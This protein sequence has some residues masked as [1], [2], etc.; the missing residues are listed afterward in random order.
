MT[1]DLKCENLYIECPPKTRSPGWH[2]W[3][4]V[5][6]CAGSVQWKISQSL[7]HFLFLYFTSCPQHELF[8]SATCSHHDVLPLHM[9]QP[10]SP[11]LLKPWASSL[12]GLIV[13]DIYHSN[14]TL[15]NRVIMKRTYFSS[16]VLMHP[17]LLQPSTMIQEDSDHSKCSHGWCSPNSCSC[18][19]S[20]SS[21]KILHP[22][23]AFENGP[24][25][26]PETFTTTILQNQTGPFMPS[27]SEK[28]PVPP[29]LGSLPP[30]R[31]SASNI[32]IHM[33]LKCNSLLS[34]TWC[35]FHNAVKE[36]LLVSVLP[37][38][39]EHRGWTCQMK[40]SH[41]HKLKWCPCSE[42]E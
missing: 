6:P 40:I 9:P 33:C 36:T 8:G 39:P 7:G 26:S 41:S 13:S 10:M 11:N 22:D 25:P 21:N 27:L 4:V 19:C 20:Q 42:H 12:C 15:A 3:T 18:S 16:S 5:E 38:Q 14:R 30:P 24:H 17:M 28:D 1:I 31:H 35:T 29:T 37:E 32:N 23:F 2:Y 34:F